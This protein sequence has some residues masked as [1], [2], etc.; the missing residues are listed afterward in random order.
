[1]LNSDPALLVGYDSFSNVEFSG[2]LYVDTTLDDDYVGLVF[3][4]Q[5]NHRFILVSWKQTTQ[6]YWNNPS[7]NG[8]AGLQIQ[9][10]R[11][12][13]GPSQALANALWHSRNTKKQVC[14]SS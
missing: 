11:S 2:T 8:E 12:K 1:M 9:L 4:Y 10:I 3:N 5:S 13:T 6:N 7:S 14:R